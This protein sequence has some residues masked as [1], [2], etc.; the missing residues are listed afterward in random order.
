MKNKPKKM[1][2]YEI[3]GSSERDNSDFENNLKKWLSEKETDENLK[4]FA[5][6]LGSDWTPDDF[7]KPARILSYSDFEKAIAHKKQ[8]IAEFLEKEKNRRANQQ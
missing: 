2:G 6:R 4:T 7:G 8:D 5:K 1:G 3:L